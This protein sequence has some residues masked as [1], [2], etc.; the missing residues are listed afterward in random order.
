MLR[1][2]IESHF[3]EGTKP[4]ENANEGEKEL[5]QGTERKYW[6]VERQ[7]GEFERVVSFP[8]E[9]NTDAIKA[10]FKDGLLTVQVPKVEPQETKETVKKIAIA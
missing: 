2:K 9:I 3:E 1:G 5:Q 7:Y 6:H 10:E 8:G 4:T